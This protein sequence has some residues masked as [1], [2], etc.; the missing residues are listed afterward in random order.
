MD[1]G[2]FIGEWTTLFQIIFPD[3][4]VLMIEAQEDKRLPLMKVVEAAPE[5]RFLEIALLGAID[6]RAVEFHQMA[7]GSSVFGEQGHVPRTIITK[8]SRTLDSVVAA[9]AGFAEGSDFIKLD[10]QGCE[11]EILKG[12]SR[13][14][15]QCQVVLM[16][17]SLLP[18]N[19]GCPL[20]HEVM[21]FMDEMGFRL[22]DFCSLLRRKDGISWQT[23]LLFLRKTS[24]YLPKPELSPENWF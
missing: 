2:A 18:V 13:I 21:I 24:P 10:V 3:T 20:I 6:G 8:T 15:P 12:A 17:A 22:I 7:S 5:K 23:D 4:P 19:S 16:E 11:L 9:H 1:I 14:L